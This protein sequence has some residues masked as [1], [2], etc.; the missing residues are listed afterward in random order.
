MVPRRGMAAA[1]MGG[2]GQGDEQSDA[3]APMSSTVNAAERI[4]KETPG[5]PSRQCASVYVR[6]ADQ[7]RQLQHLNYSY[8]Y[9]YKNYYTIQSDKLQHHHPLASTA[10]IP[11]LRQHSWYPNTAINAPTPGPGVPAANFSRKN[12]IAAFCHSLYACN[13]SAR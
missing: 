7:S 8:I 9:V 5:L 11:V 1:G 13:T 2:P 12:R 4:A 10:S 6:H 3:R